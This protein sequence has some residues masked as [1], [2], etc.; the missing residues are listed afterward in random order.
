[1]NKNLKFSFLTILILIIV[2]C[3]FY[4]KPTLVVKDIKVEKNVAIKIKPYNKDSVIVFIPYKFK[5]YNNRFKRFK[6]PSV[7]Y[8]SN[9]FSNDES[10]YFDNKGKSTDY[11]RYKIIKD[12]LRD[13]GN[14]IKEYIHEKKYEFSYTLF[15]FSS[16]EFY[17]YKSYLI[18][19]KL[20]RNEFLKLHE[21][22]RD[23]QKRNLYNKSL[24]SV[25]NKTIDSINSS[26]KNK[27]LLFTFYDFSGFRHPTYQIA[28]YFDRK[29]QVLTNT[30]K[31]IIKMN[32]QQLYNY[33]SSKTDEDY[34]N[35]D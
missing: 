7:N 29:P 23:H 8:K 15:P 4:S 20:K 3:Y 10:L 26:D 33:L 9:F 6:S 16:K 30:H 17:F 18:K 28:Y 13:N 24:I 27:K 32:R 12:S 22:F 19:K 14:P 34:F 2:F 21:N 1:M 31:I 11:D 25:S 35:K 5:V